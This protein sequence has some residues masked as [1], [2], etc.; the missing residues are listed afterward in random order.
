MYIK[1]TI[2]NVFEIGYLISLSLSPLSRKQF[3]STEKIPKVKL[4]EIENHN[5]GMTY[6]IQVWQFSLYFSP[7][8]KETKHNGN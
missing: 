7:S 2:V 4:S 8:Y 3:Y 5:I 6:D 1:H